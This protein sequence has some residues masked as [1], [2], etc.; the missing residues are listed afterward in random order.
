MYEEKNFAGHPT[1]NINFVICI[2]Y[3]ANKHGAVNCFPLVEN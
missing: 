3:S 2:N 1:D